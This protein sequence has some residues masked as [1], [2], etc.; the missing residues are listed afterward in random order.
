[1][2]RADNN[3]CIDNYH[4]YTIYRYLWVDNNFMFASGLGLPLGRRYG[5]WSPWI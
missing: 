5:I 1:M 3:Q 2:N 4:F